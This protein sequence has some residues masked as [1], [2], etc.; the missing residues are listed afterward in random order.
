MKESGGAQHSR[1][2]PTPGSGHLASG[3]DWVLQGTLA[4]EAGLGMVLASRAEPVPGFERAVARYAQELD[5]SGI[6]VEFTESDIVCAGLMRAGLLAGRRVAAVLSMRGLRQAL[7]ALYE[8]RRI[9]VGPHGGGVIV[10]CETRWPSHG[11]SLPISLGGRKDTRRSL[12]WPAPVDARE[13]ALYLGLPILAPADP[14]EVKRFVNEAVRLSRASGMPSILILSPALLGGGETPWFVEDP[15]LKPVP[16]AF[17]ATGDDPAGPIQIEARRRHIDR[18][19]NGPGPGETVPRGFI[20]FGTAHAALRHALNL[21]GLT[22]RLPILKLGYANPVDRRSIEQFLSRCEEVHVIETGRPIV[23]QQVTSIAWQMN[24][25][26]VPTAKIRGRDDKMGMNSAGDTVAEWHPSDLV[27]Q[28]GPLV[29]SV[30]THAGPSVRDRLMGLE[31]LASGTKGVRFGQGPPVFRRGGLTQRVVRKVL[32]EIAEDL[33]TASEDR[34]AMELV[35]D[36]INTALLEYGQGQIAVIEIQRRHMASV[37]RAAIVHALRRRLQMTFLIVPDPPDHPGGIT[38]VEV[39]RMVRSLVSDA[40]TSRVSISTLHASQ[41]RA[42]RESLR[43]EILDDRVS[44]LI[45]DLEGSSRNKAHRAHRPAA[46]LDDESA[47]TL[48]SQTRVR[49][50]SLTST[51]CHEWLIHHG[52][53]D[54]RKLDGV[55]GPKIEWPDPENPTVTP[56]DGWDGFEELKVTHGKAP[57]D[58]TDIV[59][60]TGLSAP[61]PRHRRE[62][63]WRCHIGG[64]PGPAFEAAQSIIADAGQRMGYRVQVVHGQ[65]PSGVFTQIVFSHPRDGEAAAPITARI[66]FGCADTVLALDRASLLDAIDEQSLHRV[67]SH[68]RTAVVVDMSEAAEDLTARALPVSEMPRSLLPLA[69]WQAVQEQDTIAVQ[70]T[71]WSN[72]LLNTTTVSGAILAGAAFQRGLIPVDADCL[73]RATRGAAQV[74]DLPQATSAIDLGRL[75]VSREVDMREE[76]AER[77]P[78]TPEALIRVHQRSLASASR[79]NAERFSELAWGSLDAM[80]GLRRRDPERE[81]DR[82]F[83][84]RLIDCERWGGI[85]IA[86]SYADRVQSVYAAERSVTDYPITRQV[87][88]ELSRAI[89]YCDPIFVSATV[90]RPDRRRRDERRLH[91][92]RAADDRMSVTIRGRSRLPV[93]RNLIGGYWRLGPV[94][95]HILGRLRF[96]RWWPWWMR[97]EQEYATWVMWLVDRC[98]EDLPDAGSLWMEVFRQLERV[99]GCAPRRYAM[100]ARARSAIESMLELRGIDVST[101]DKRWSWLSLMPPLGDEED[102]SPGSADASPTNDPSPLDSPPPPPA[103]LTRSS[104]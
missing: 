47:E 23:E 102:T 25:A 97:Q 63:Y 32:E 68:S 89:L 34:P 59:A 37:G 33:A 8:I 21:M 67:A 29:E 15:A 6:L 1:S 4:S 91:L 98:I 24:Q 49:P 12:A 22:N 79:R 83:V 2:R 57:E 82:I 50:T 19:I 45:L 20:T 96:L 41:G 61:P 94:G 101:P 5:D 104:E 58:V 80:T 100:A 87:I 40:D 77:A 39:E 55:Q 73:V 51:L 10:A 74:L 62:A 72:R 76:A 54:S 103:P 28:L 17:D 53:Q 36:N 30:R 95:C 13:L 3:V 48:L 65:S 46:E 11:R 7:D 56:L 60:R 9:R 42:L 85:R 43:A 88:D 64:Q 86:R 18:L 69:I 16:A 31:T 92:S 52:W 26:G 84:S 81:T 44:V 93:V 66:P 27:H 38:S 35:V 70:A 71:D 14:V 90:I 78:A 75:L 99:R